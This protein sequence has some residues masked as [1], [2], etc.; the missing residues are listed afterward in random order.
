MRSPKPSR[1]AFSASPN[2]FSW[3]T[4]IQEAEL[5]ISKGKERLRRL[6]RSVKI[7]KKLANQG[8][9][10]PKPESVLRAT[11]NE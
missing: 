11:D 8:V 6:R 3:L 5:Q 7:F 1:Q 10:Y 9:E 4:A 2:D